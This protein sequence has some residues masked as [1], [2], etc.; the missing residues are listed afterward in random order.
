VANEGGWNSSKN[1]GSAGRTRPPTFGALDRGEDIPSRI[2]RLNALVNAFQKESVII[3]KAIAP[4]VYC[5]RLA[6]LAAL[7]EAIRGAESARIV[8]GRAWHRISLGRK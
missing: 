7:G 1:C 3:T 6:Y 8:L 5:E 4:L 2:A